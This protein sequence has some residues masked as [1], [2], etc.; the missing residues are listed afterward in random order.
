M[1][2]EPVEVAAFACDVAPEG[3][4]VFFWR[5]EL[6][7]ADSDIVAHGDWQGVHHVSL[8]GV[9]VL[10]NLGQQIEERSPQARVY[11]V[12]SAVEATLGDRLLYIVVLFQKRASLLDVPS[13]ESR[14]HQGDSHHL[15]S[16]QTDLW[17]IT[18]ADGL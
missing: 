1:H 12:Q 7:A 6:A 8:L 14:C 11:G 16:G 2:P 4:A 17:I 9:L 10:E 5:I 15:G 18:V 13:E 3:L